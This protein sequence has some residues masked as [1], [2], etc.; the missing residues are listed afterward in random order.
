MP[1]AFAVPVNANGFQ[2]KKGS[3]VF[4]RVFA[5]FQTSKAPNSITSLMLMKVTIG[6]T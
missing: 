3:N 1:H 5:L 4:T 6:L 2:R